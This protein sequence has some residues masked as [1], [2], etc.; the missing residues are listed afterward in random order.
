MEHDAFTLSGVLLII[1]ANTAKCCL[2]LFLF[3]SVCV[4]ESR[5]FDSVR[6]FSSFGHFLFS[7][8][9]LTFLT[10]FFLWL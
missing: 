1:L 4:T 7:S 6:A 9:L 2:L 10:G 8:V 3:T 5:V